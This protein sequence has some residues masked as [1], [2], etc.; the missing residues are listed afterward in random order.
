MASFGDFAGRPPS[1]K[2]GSAHRLG[3]GGFIG[4]ET[5]VK[6]VVNERL[7]GFGGRIAFSAGQS[8]ARRGRCG[9]SGVVRG[10]SRETGMGVASDPR[11]STRKVSNLKFGEPKCWG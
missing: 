2:L 9:K 6:F 5:N 11:D 8:L 4:F 10:G 7:F 3:F 1:E